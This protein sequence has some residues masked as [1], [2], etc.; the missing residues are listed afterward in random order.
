MYCPH[1]HHQLTSLLSSTRQ[2]VQPTCL[3]FWRCTSEIKVRHTCVCSGSSSAVLQQNQATSFSDVS[4]SL[5]RNALDKLFAAEAPPTAI[6]SSRTAHSLCVLGIDP[7]ISGAVAVLQWDLSSSDTQL[8]LQDAKIVLHD[9]PITSVVIGKR[10]QRQADP[11]GISKLMTS[12]NLSSST[13]VRAIL[14]HPIPNALNGK[15]SWFSSGYNSGIW[16]GVLLSH[17]IPFETVSARVWKTDMQLLKTGKE[18]SRELAQQLLPQTTP[19]LKRKKDHGRA[20]ALL[21]A[22]WGIGVRRTIADVTTA[23]AEPL[24]ALDDLHDDGCNS[25]E[26]LAMAMPFKTPN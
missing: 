13:E 24:A 21:L 6:C 8:Q 12:L 19:Q 22:A 1:A 20:E 11:L 18:G 16:K 3:R 15:W 10:L 7:D 9:M 17:G 23:N 4:Q 5:S 2:A 26:T 14:E 25:H